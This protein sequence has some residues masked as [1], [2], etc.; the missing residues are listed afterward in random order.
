MLRY[1]SAS[2]L[3]V[4]RN[5]RNTRHKT[6]ITCHHIHISACGSRRHLRRSGTNPYSL[7]ST[8]PNRFQSPIMLALSYKHDISS[9]STHPGRKQVKSLAPHTWLTWKEIGGG[10]GGGIMYHLRELIS[11]FIASLHFCAECCNININENRIWTE[12]IGL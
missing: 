10:G 9:V 11:V 3:R 6:L 5:F 4:G 7:S 1:C 2:E 12:Y 8:G